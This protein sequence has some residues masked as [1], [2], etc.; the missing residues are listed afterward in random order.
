MND[1]LKT[2]RKKLLQK[3]ADFIY[4]MLKNVRTEQE[5]DFWMWQ[6]LRL[7]YWCVERNIWLN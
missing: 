4:N 5:F 1:K 3:V 6:G 7:N 2:R